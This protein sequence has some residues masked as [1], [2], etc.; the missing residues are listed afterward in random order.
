MPSFLRPLPPHSQPWATINLLSASLGSPTLG[1]AYKW[2]MWPF[3][4]GFLHSECFQ[5]A[6]MLEHL[7]V[8]HSFYCQFNIPLYGYTHVPLYIQFHH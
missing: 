2:Y 6:F 5:H 3:V 8:P 4:T 1:I 7:S